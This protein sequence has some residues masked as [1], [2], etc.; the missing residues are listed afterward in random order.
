LRVRG[1]SARTASLA[2]QQFCN[3]VDF[4]C[5]KGDDRRTAR[6]T[7]EFARSGVKQLGKARPELDVG[8]GQHPPDHRFHGLG[9]QNHGLLT[10]AHIEQAIGKDVPAVEIGCGLNLVDGNEI[11]R[12][13]GGHRLDGRNPVTRGLGDDPLLAGHKRYGLGANALEDAVVDFA[14]QKPQRQPDHTG[15]IGQHALDGVVGLARIG[16]SE[17][18]FD[19]L[20][21]RMKHRL[22]ND[23]RFGARS[24]IS[25]LKCRGTIP[26]W[27]IALGKAMARLALCLTIKT[28]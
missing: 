28:K 11:D 4:G 9:A 21:R 3:G 12:Q 2:A 16:R 8:M 25:A 19:R 26:R 10:P 17:H 23:Y 14:R 22:G 13:V 20:G 1:D 5:G 15:P 27:G 24:G 6:Q 7:R 18:R